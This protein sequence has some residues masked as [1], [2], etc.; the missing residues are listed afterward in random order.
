MH[1]D[2]LSESEACVAYAFEFQLRIRLGMRVA[3]SQ[4]LGLV[5]QG[6]SGFVTGIFSTRDES[7]LPDSVLWAGGSPRVNRTPRLAPLQIR[8]AIKRRLPLEALAR[9]PE[10]NGARPSQSG[11]KRPF[12]AEERLW[13]YRQLTDAER[14]RLVKAVAEK[15]DGYFVQVLLDEAHF[16]GEAEAFRR[17]L[18]ISLEGSEEMGRESD[19]VSVLQSVSVFVPLSRGHV[20]Y[21]ARGFSSTFVFS[22]FTLASSLPIGEGRLQTVVRT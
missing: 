8:S 7:A 10:S 13:V 20:R 4:F 15:L 1:E 6:S 14:E 16:G 9:R 19:A 5:P 18:R 2:A 12:T 21:G 22:G 11:Q 17:V 3:Y